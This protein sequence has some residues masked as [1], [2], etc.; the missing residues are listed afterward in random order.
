MK[1]DEVQAIFALARIPV[2]ASKAL[3]DGYGYGP[4]DPRLY[5]TPPRCVWWFVKTPFGW[6]EIGWRK[7][8]ISIDWT[9]TKV[10]KIITV[11]YTTKDETSVHAWTEAKA[12]EYLTALAKADDELSLESRPEQGHNDIHQQLELLEKLR[13]AFPVHAEHRAYCDKG[14]APDRPCTCGLEELLAACL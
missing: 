1:P 10:R 6:I 14:N 8:V 13:T 4:H 7:R 12:I 9:D 3:I 2:L 11:D 5:E